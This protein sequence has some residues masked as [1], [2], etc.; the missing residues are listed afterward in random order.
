[1]TARGSAREEKETDQHLSPLQS[2][3]CSARST[4]SGMSVVLLS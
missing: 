2:F 4:M 1:M 3:S